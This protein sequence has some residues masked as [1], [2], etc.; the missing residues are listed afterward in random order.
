MLVDLVSVNFG[1]STNVGDVRKKRK[2]K[3]HW[4]CHLFSEAHSKIYYKSKFIEIE[5]QSKNN[6][7]QWSH[8]TWRKKPPYSIATWQREMADFPSL[9]Y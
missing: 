5:A 3:T 7:N 9:L 1:Y 6:N 2:P 8:D 4:A